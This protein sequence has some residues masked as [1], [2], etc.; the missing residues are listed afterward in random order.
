MPARRR[1]VELQ[2]SVPAEPVPA[3]A[4][5]AHVR[6]AL[7]NVALARLEQV[8]ERSRMTLEAAAGGARLACADE[9]RLGDAA[10][11]SAFRLLLAEPADAMD[12]LRLARALV[13][14]EGGEFEI[15][16]PASGT[17]IGFAFP[18]A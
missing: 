16:C 6:Q 15:D 14:S 3:R 8:P 7:V 18:A 1:K 5:R 2:V 17:R 13:E 10:R 11:A 12:G 9:G 4:S